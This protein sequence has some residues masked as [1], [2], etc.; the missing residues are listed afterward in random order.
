[1]AH[2]ETLY[3]VTDRVATIT[4]NR[5]DKLNAWTGTMEQEV[6]A[7]IHE[8]EQD[9]DVRVIILTGAGRGFCA[10]ADMSL[11]GEI[12]QK[13]VGERA[14]ALANTS[15]GQRAGV[16]PDFQKKYSYFPSIQKPVIAAVNGPAVGLGFVIT[17]YCD[18]R[19]ASDAAR[20]GTAFARRGLIAEYGLAWMLPRL[21]GPA[22]ALDM[23]F[24]ARLVEANEALR[25]G[26]VNRVFPQDQFLE[27]VRA[28]AKEL[29]YSVSPR[30]MRVMKDQVYA[31]MFQTLSEA[32]E[33]SEQE[34][35]QSLQC[36]DFK[37][38][39]AH[40]LQKRAPAFTGK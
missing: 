9:P 3:Q 33:S 10:G 24:S 27:G 7:S 18:L 15:N 32:F 37:E 21:I 19:F 25:M 2:Q 20:F 38:G 6:R 1:M 4:L 36:E 5:P 30:S 14:S 8:A 11:L 16:R 12:A 34:M 31:A 13:G 28:Y 22:N 23:L 17:L 26:L 40:F 35:L 39:V 29:A